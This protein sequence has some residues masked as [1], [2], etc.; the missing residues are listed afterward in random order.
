MADAG[1]AG[2]R[3]LVLGGGPGGYAA[4][5]LGAELGLDVT[6]VD[7]GER[8]GGV[9][10]YRG[11]IPSKAL[12]HLAA[13]IHEARAAARWGVRFEPPQ[14]DL[15]ALRAHRDKIVDQLTNGL[16]L[17]TKNRK[18]RF[19]QGRGRFTSPT[20]LHVRRDSE[21]V[22]IDF[23][24]AIVATG[25]RPAIPGP[26]RI[27]SPRVMDSTGALELADIPERLLIVG[28]GY[29]GLEM[30]SVY[31]AL[32]SR[33]TVVEMLDGLLPGIDRDLVRPLQHKLE[34]EFTAILLNTRVVSMVEVDNGI[35]AQLEDDEGTI[36]TAEFDKVLV[37]VGRVPNTQDLGLEN[38]A[39]QI[40]TGEFLNV[41]AQRRTAEPSIFAIGDVTGEPMLAH[42]A[43][44][45]GRVAAEV[46]AGE[47][48]A[49]EPAAIPAVVFTNPELAWSGLTESQAAAKREIDF[50]VVKIPWG[51]SGRAVTMDHPE[52]LTKLIIE[53]KTGRLLGAGITGANAGE[54]IGEATLAI[55]MGARATDLELTIHAHPTLSETIMETAESLYGQATHYLNKP[56]T[57][58]R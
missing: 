12:L 4:A 57:M 6:L 15:E 20:S 21:L 23:D 11:C 45:E 43:T 32:G 13:T 38:T 10:L 35:E 16:A 19:V 5:V 17:I 31:A 37:A 44:R 29:I 22:E 51:A 25:S 1:T 3:L 40:N 34:A 50:D 46:I 49:F 18:V 56:L 26:L 58:R 2:I 30:G 48:T 53:Q 52:G 24:Q 42:K 8:P 55:E 33:V 36:T 41:D 47:P 27:D 14:I 54:L 28:G 39:V 9:C 7:E